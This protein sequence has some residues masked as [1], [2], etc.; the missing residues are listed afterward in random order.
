MSTTF[1]PTPTPGTAARS[2]RPGGA[3]AAGCAGLVAAVAALAGCGRSAPIDALSD[4]SGDPDIAG[5]SVTS[6][7]A[8]VETV[9]TAPGETTTTALVAPAQV[10]YTIQPGDTLSVIATQ[11]DVT[12]EALAQANGIT[13]VNNI[14]PGQELVIPVAPVEVDV[15]VDT[16]L[17]PASPEQP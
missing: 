14:R 12:I 7:D 13:D 17:E 2:R 3:V 10:F 1:P 6:P 11:Y 16:A 5:V 9:P 4:L 15:A 8:V